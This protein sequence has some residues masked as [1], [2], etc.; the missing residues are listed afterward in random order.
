MDREAIIREYID[1]SLHLSLGTCIDNKPWVC[2]VHFVYDNHLNLYFRSLRSRRH[3]QEIANNSHVAGN[4][5]KQHSIDEYPHAIYFEG[6]ATIVEDEAEKLRIF[7]YFQSRLGARKEI[8]EEAR[9]EE[10]HQFYKV[11]VTAWYAFGTFGQSSGQKVELQWDGGNG[12]SLG[13]DPVPH[14]DEPGP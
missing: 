9:K 4:I 6:T 7:P 12:G 14:T 8:L 1:K 13:T 5:V 10:G 11:T 2:E 3:S